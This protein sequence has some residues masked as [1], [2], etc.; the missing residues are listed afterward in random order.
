MGAAGGQVLAQGE[1]IA[2]L[3]AQVGHDRQH[4]VLFLAKAEHEPGLGGDIRVAFLEG[5]QQGQGAGIVGAGAGL[6]IE[7]GDRLQ[8][9]IEEVW[10]AVAS[11]L[12]EGQGLAT[13]KVG[14]QHLQPRVRTAAANGAQAS[15]E[16]AGAAIAQ[17]VAV[18]GG[19]DHVA[20]PRAAM[21]W[22]RCSGSSGSGAGR[23]WATSQKGQ[24]RVQTSPRIMKV[25]VPWLKHSPRLGHWASSQTVARRASR[26]RRLMRVTP[27]PMGARARIQLGLR[28]RLGQGLDLDRDAG[29]LVLA[30]LVGLGGGAGRGSEGRGV[31]GHGVIPGGGVNKGSQGCEGA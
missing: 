21:D 20:R 16:V 6:G 5:A 19:D 7:P 26:N 1:H 15:G 13:A 4:L 22:A 29:H 18:D 12:S 28:K 10:P 14:H 8:V 17:I 25:A 11:E 24:R 31:V 27:G 9:V 3:G 2:A 23:P 30:P